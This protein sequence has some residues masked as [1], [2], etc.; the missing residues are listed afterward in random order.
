MNFKCASDL[1]YPKVQV[2]QKNVLYGEILLQDYVGMES[3]ETAIHNYLYQSVIQESHKEI[4]TCLE[5][6][7]KV[8]MHHQKI[9]AKLINL[10]GVDPK[11]RTI[12]CFQDRPIYWKAQYVNYEQN[13]E[14]ALEIAIRSEER[15]I[16]QYQNHIRIIQDKY[17]QEVLKR[18]ILDENL[19]IETLKN[20]QNSLK[21]RK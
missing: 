11:Y 10:L 12:E 7:A 18:I 13:I 19:H 6:L 15:A 14:K 1:P 2:E 8:E 17:I 16:F 5:Q 3:E 9:L 20:L 21:Q 4:A